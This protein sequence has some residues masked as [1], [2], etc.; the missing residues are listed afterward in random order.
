M[1]EREK[2]AFLPHTTTI[3]DAM[4]MNRRKPESTNEANGS[5]SVELQKYLETEG[6]FSLVR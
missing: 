4:S 2:S 5:E 6:H 3:G 1:A